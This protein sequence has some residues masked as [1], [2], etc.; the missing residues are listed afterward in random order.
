MSWCPEGQECETFTLKMKCPFVRLMK[1]ELR[2]ILPCCRLGVEHFWDSPLYWQEKRYCKTKTVTLKSWGM[3][4]NSKYS[5]A[6]MFRLDW[7]IW[8]YWNICL[9]KLFFRFPEMVISIGNSWFNVV[10]F[11]MDIYMYVTTFS[12]NPYDHC[13]SKNLSFV[14]NHQEALLVWT[15]ISLYD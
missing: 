4:S 2:I 13:S 6:L 12:L 10:E 7:W 14:H 11:F 5:G 8:L 1:M 9:D 15:P 3:V